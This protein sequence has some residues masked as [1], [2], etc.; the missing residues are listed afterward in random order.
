MCAKLAVI[1]VDIVKNLSISN[2]LLAQSQQSDDYLSVIRENISLPE[3]R[4]PKFRII[5]KVLYK[6]INEPTYG[7]HKYVICL[8]DILMPSVV[9]SLHLNLGHA[10]VKTTQRNFEHY[11]YHRT[12]T[13]LIKSYIRSCTTCTF[14]SKYDVKKV[15]LE[16][17]RSLQPTRPRQYIYCNLIPMFRGTLSYILFCLDAY[18][19][20]IY[21]IPLKDKTSISVLQGLLWLFATTGWP[22]AIYLDNETSLQNYLSKWHQ[23][24]YTTV[25]RTVNS[26]IGVKI[27]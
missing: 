2:H 20:F 14:A 12:S 19:Q 23:L 11:Y 4:F 8:P 6:E 16:T 13:K 7:S 21:A 5:N 22:E 24:K 3:N 18:S 25:H 15:I 26:K 9:H 1:S 10:S 17:E 27:T